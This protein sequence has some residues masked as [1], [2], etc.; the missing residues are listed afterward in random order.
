MKKHILIIEDDPFLGALLLQKLQLEEFEVTLVADGAQGLQQISALKP[1]L[2]L[3]DIILPTMNGYEILEARQKN[4]M[5]SRIPVIIIS[6]SG[7][8][9]EIQRALALGI[10][11]YLVKAQMDPEDVL[12][13]VRSF[14]Q[15]TSVVLSESSTTAG[16]LEGKKVLWVED[17]AFL[18][19]LVAVKLKR[20]GCVAYYAKDGEQ[21]IEILKTT[22]P[23]IILLDLVLP[24]MSG[25]DVLSQIK[26]N[27]VCKS[28]PVMILSNLGQGKD[29]E[30]S[31]KLGA[32]KHLV[33]A[34]HDLDDIIGEIVTILKN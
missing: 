18:S 20:Q 28:V 12:A 21:A 10:S 27:P 1:D 30:R 6:N 3:L 9:V 11:D 32:V 24:G 17:D 2:V 4:P 7:Q 19:D 26:A 13:K 31:M 22:T 16:R 34:E 8:P 33:K 14:F 23:D 15:S 5:I 29:I 25:F